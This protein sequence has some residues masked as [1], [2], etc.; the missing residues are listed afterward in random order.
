M[1]HEVNGENEAL[2]FQKPQKKA[3]KRKTQPPL[4]LLLSQN[5]ISIQILQQQYFLI[6]Y[7]PVVMQKVELSAPIPA[8]ICEDSTITPTQE[9]CFFFFAFVKHFTHQNSFSA[10][11]RLKRTC[12][13]CRGDHCLLFFVSAPPAPSD[14]YSL[15]SV[16]LFC[17]A[18][19]AADCSPLLTDCLCP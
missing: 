12:W 15:H 1:F 2:Q 14:A 3:T 8:Q 19:A 9:H 17:L 13:D 16:L 18:R 4:R 10:W 7:F 5:Q 11:E 6:L